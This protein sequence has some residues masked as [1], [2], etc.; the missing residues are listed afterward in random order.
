MS[1]LKS[2][3]AQFRLFHGSMTRIRIIEPWNNLN[4]ATVIY[5]KVVFSGVDNCAG[6]KQFIRMSSC[7]TDNVDTL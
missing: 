7:D 1:E 6:N 4:C 2:T 3:V 5:A